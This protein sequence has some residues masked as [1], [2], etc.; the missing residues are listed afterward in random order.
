MVSIF[1][2][3]YYI[4]YC[5]SAFGGCILSLQIIC[6]IEILICIF[7]MVNHIYIYMNIVFHKIVTL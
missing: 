5:W 6:D 4:L 2:K 3:D 7:I 1:E